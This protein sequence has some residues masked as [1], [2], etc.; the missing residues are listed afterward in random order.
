MYGKNDKCILYFDPLFLLFSFIGT[1]GV[2]QKKDSIKRK[3]ASKK[4][5]DIPAVSFS[6]SLSQY[7]PKSQGVHSEASDKPRFFEYVP[8]GQPFGTE[9]PSWQ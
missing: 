2:K 1:Q 7:F 3:Q 8:T 4:K 9:V 5:G 6:P